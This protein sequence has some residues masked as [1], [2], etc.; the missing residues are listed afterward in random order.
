MSGVVDYVCADDV[1]KADEHGNPNMIGPV[2]RDEELFAT[3]E[4]FFVGQMI[5]MIVAHSEEQARAA[6]K[7]V[8]V[9]YKVLPALFT[10]EDAIEKECFFEA[11]RTIKSGVFADKH[12]VPLDVATHSVE[13]VARISAQE[14]FYLETQ[15]ALVVPGKEDDEVEVY[16]STQNP[17]ETQDFVAHVLG[18]SF[19]R[20]VCRVKRL[21]GGFGGKESR[22]LFVSCGAAVAAKKVKRPVRC[23][24][25]REEDMVMSGTRHPFLGKYKVGF[26]DQG[27]LISLDLKMYANAGYS[28]DLSI[29]VLE[30]SLTHVDNAYKIPNMNLYG[31]LCKTNTASNTA[32]RGFGGPQGM[33]VAEQYIT[34]VANYLNKP[35]EEIRKLNLYKD[36]EVTHFDM[37]LENVYL[38]RAWEELE[39]SS[40]FVK[41]RAMVDEYNSKNR[42]RKRG[43]VMMPTKFGL[44]FTARFLNQAAALVHV[45]TD[46]SV[47]VAHGGTEMGQGLHTK[48]LQITADAFQIPIDRVF[49]SETRTDTCINTS[50]TAASVSSDING[51]A[52]LNA[53]E[54][55]MARLKPLKEKNPDFSWEKVL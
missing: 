6:A 23:I 3:K 53:C 1:A 25:S 41:R 20:V 39:K 34:H 30:R 35:V 31:R 32:F 17:K 19:N 24:L 55:I 16:A 11:V 21:G 22:S 47:K 52:V 43:I 13:G 33:M 44:A 10:C 28:H 54:Q 48:M 15:S 5:G 51:M 9:V 49:V 7:K 36:G 27:K 42:Y 37:P 2:F 46:G 45:Y 8:K 40:D 50:A 26:T 29:A 12:D 14:H 18:I 38:H 4:V